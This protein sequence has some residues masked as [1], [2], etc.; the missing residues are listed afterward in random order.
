MNLSF[1][2]YGSTFNGQQRWTDYRTFLATAF[3]LIYDSGYNVDETVLGTV[4][5]ICVC[6]GIFCSMWPGGWVGSTPAAAF[7][8]LTIHG[9][10]VWNSEPDDMLAVT[11][12]NSVPKD[13]VS[14]VMAWERR[15]ESVSSVERD[16]PAWSFGWMIWTWPPSLRHRVI[17]AAVSSFEAA[18]PPVAWVSGSPSTLATAIGPVRSLWRLTGSHCD[19]CFFR[20]CWRSLA[21]LA[22]CLWQQLQACATV[23][24]LPTVAENVGFG[25]GPSTPPTPLLAPAGISAPGWTFWIWVLRFELDL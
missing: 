8:T 1:H 14:S 10:T 20:W 2:P 5:S 13:W 3:V 12:R 9:T 15:S 18:A 21:L 19:P 24:M 6:A 17:I 11:S 25:S 7:G 16:T 23:R 4:C 22:Y